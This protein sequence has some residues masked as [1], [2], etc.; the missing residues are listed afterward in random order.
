MRFKSVVPLR[1]LRP[2][3]GAFDD[4]QLPETEGWVTV[5]GE[6]RLSN[7]IFVAS[8]QGRSMEPQI[9]DGAYCLFRRGVV[10]PQAGAI[11]LVELRGEEDPEHGGR[12]T[13][14]PYRPR[15]SQV[16]SPDGDGSL[17]VGVLE[18]LNPEV[19]NIEV[20]PAEGGRL[21]PIAEFV[22]VV[23]RGPPVRRSGSG[24]L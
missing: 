18:S 22:R 6:D 2:A 24:R 11:L 10:R 14:K 19:P 12:Y 4:Q 8:V 1:S 20:R 3:A 15:R 17:P 16:P 5:P 23:S 9:P 21:R 7:R 13:I